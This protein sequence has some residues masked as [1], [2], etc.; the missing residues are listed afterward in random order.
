[1]KA[2]VIK[3][4]QEKFKELHIE[5]VN[6]VINFCKENNID[7]DEFYLNADALHTSINFGKWHPCTD[8]CFELVK[9]NE[10]H[11]RETMMISM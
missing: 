5:L 1:M 7:V 11:E 2:N 4:T 9:L 8:S 10:N 3:S 6:I